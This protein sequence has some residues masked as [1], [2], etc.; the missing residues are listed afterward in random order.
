MAWHNAAALALYGCGHPGLMMA[1]GRS[2]AEVS[3]MLPSLPDAQETVES[4]V[5]ETSMG[6]GSMIK[7]MVRLAGCENKSMLF[8]AQ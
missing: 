2:D 7:S 6:V 4:M 8:P 1:P 3:D 5:R